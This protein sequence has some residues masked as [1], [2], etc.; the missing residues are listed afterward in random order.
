MLVAGE[1]FEAFKDSVSEYQGEIERVKEENRC[2][3]ETLAEIDTNRV[4]PRAGSQASYADGVR[5]HSSNPE[6]LDSEPSVIQ[7]KLELAT[8]K[9]E[10]EPPPSL[11]NPYTC[12][13]SPTHS[14]EP[15][16]NI[17]ET[18]DSGLNTD[19]VL[20]VKAEPDECQTFPSS[21]RR[22]SGAQDK[23]DAGDERDP[24]SCSYCDQTFDEVSHLASHLQSHMVLFN[25]EVCGKSFKKKG[26]LRTHMIVH[27][28]E[29]PFRCKL[30]GKSYSC[31]KVLNVHLISHTGERPF[32]CGYCEKRFKLKSHLKEHERIHTGEKPFSCPVCR[33]CFSRSN[34]VKIHIRSRH[35]E[36]LHLIDVSGGGAMRGLLELRR[37]EEAAAEV[38]F[39]MACS[40]KMAQL[41]TLNSFFCERLLAVAAEI[42][43]AVKDTLSEYQ[44]EVDRSK[45]EIVYLRKMLAEVSISTGADAQT[46]QADE[47]PVEQHN[48]NE[49]PLESS[50]IQ[51]KLEL[52]AMEQETESQ[53]PSCDAATCC[54]PADAVKASEPP[55]YKTSAMAEQTEDI[56]VHMD[57]HVT[58]KLEQCPDEL[59]S[60][61]I[62][63]ES[64]WNHFRNTEDEPGP[65]PSSQC[66][67]SHQ[68]FHLQSPSTENVFHYKACGKPFKGGLLKTHM[69]VHHK[70]RTYRC[71]LCGKCYSTSYALKLHLRT[72]TGER[73]YTCKFCVKTFN[74]KAHV[75]EHERIHTGEKPYSCSVCGKHFNRTYQVKVHIR[76]Y[77]PDEV[78]TIIRSRQHNCT[79]YTLG[80]ST[81]IEC[82]A[83]VSLR[84]TEE[85][86]FAMASCNNVLKFE[87]L[88]VFIHE[89]LTATAG[90]IFQAVKD[91]L[92]EFQEEIYR[93]TQ[94]NI[95]LK[96][97]LADVSSSE[98]DAQTKQDEFP[99]E[100]ENPE[101]QVKLEFSTVHQD[102]GT[103]SAC[104]FVQ[105][106]TAYG[107]PH[108]ASDKTVNC[109]DS[110][111][112]QAED[113]SPQNTNHGP[114]D[115]VVQV[116][117]ELSTVQQDAEPQ[118]PCFQGIKETLLLF[119]SHVH[120]ADEKAILG[121][122]F[123][124]FYEH[125]LKTKGNETSQAVPQELSNFNQEPLD[126][127]IQVKVELSTMHQDA[128]SQGPPNNPSSSS[129]P[130]TAAAYQ[131]PSYH[132]SEKTANEEKVE[133]GIHNSGVT[134]KLEPWDSQVIYSDDGPSEMQNEIIAKSH[135]EGMRDDQGT[136]S[137][138]QIPLNNMA[139]SETLLQG[140]TV[141]RVVYCEYCGKPFGNREQLKQHLVVHQKE[142]PRPY[143]CDLCEKSY[144]YAQVLEI[145][146][147]THTGE[148]PYHSQD[149]QHT[150]ADGA[151]LEQGSTQRPLNSDPS[152]LQLKLELAAIKQEA[153]PQV[154]LND[155][156]ASTS[157]CAKSAPVY[158]GHVPEC[159]LPSPVAVSQQRESKRWADIQPCHADA[160]Q[161]QTNQGPPDSEPDSMIQVKLELCTVQ[162]ELEPQQPLT[163][164]PC[165][166]T[167]MDTAVDQ[168]PL[169]GLPVKS[170]DTEEKGCNDMKVDPLP[171][172]AEICDSQA[173]CTENSDL[174]ATQGEQ[175]SVDY[176]E[177]DEDDSSSRSHY[178]V[179]NASPDRLS[180]TQNDLADNLFYCK[181]CNKP[182]KTYLWLEKHMASHNNEERHV[183]GVCGKRFKLAQTLESHIN[184]HTRERPHSCRFCGKGFSQKSHVRDH[185]RI[186][187]GEKPFVCPI[188][189]K[190]FVQRSQLMTHIHTH[191]YLMKDL[192]EGPRVWRKRGEAQNARCLRSKVN[193]AI[194]QEVLEHFMLPAADQLYGDADFIFQQVLAPAHSAKATS[195]WFKDHAIPVPNWPAN[196]PD[197]NPIKNLWGIVKRKMRY[198]R[199]NNA[200]E[201]KATI[202]AT[203][204]LITPE[205]CHKLI[206]SCHAA[207]LQ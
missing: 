67:F 13:S 56:G 70:A 36:Q 178:R 21:N 157:P 177:V 37:E 181:V 22:L 88:N 8:L 186:H 89:R 193:A 74:Q 94:E 17:S 146:R 103:S 27:Q 204:A 140:E 174:S 161:D 131:E 158:H 110:Q 196:S 123:G 144:S 170:M 151:P 184:N 53:Q 109:E 100:E 115:S 160:N 126:S 121:I 61:A 73:P 59:N 90:D 20:M 127:I 145:H 72:H 66:D 35:R 87:S 138:C 142:K 108:S 124:V 95:Y 114:L 60:C 69:V 112:S 199:P 28:K 111:L 141:E 200:E 128:E 82:G 173:S 183:C 150:H 97:R 18:D 149:V 4:E 75:K 49:E 175:E 91:V 48:S 40:V 147:R 98:S 113:V 81:H 206:H 9:Q 152:V 135:F 10:C 143:R 63:T 38:Q 182:F 155:P 57:S 26:T 119:A 68:S 47:G 167:H 169:P 32:G 84:P 52:S 12:T 16:W 122:P 41:E 2:L 207:F 165:S 93:S 77:H 137:Q 136:S 168:E 83:A 3:R 64:L 171:V 153:E 92:A 194:Y 191:S 39:A 104:N 25:C 44:D 14:P 71:D 190:G 51:V 19:S 162:Q 187:T 85:E 117:L 180:Q 76:N 11:N 7:V 107:P 80:G 195:T 79:K 31:A 164:V 106:A 29:R 50:V 105:E 205:Q 86:C 166:T 192:S 148:R 154:T 1:I 120:V 134:I 129:S 33:K 132:Y 172:K 197:L 125:E 54:V 43:Q 130:S 176:F 118:Q 133:D 102:P 78:A 96:R 45:R 65:H 46:S 42:Y 23:A 185:E 163:V 139:H 201:L 189:Q 202:R 5:K 116:K 99:L 30:C 198:A 156:S 24:L 15:A 179:F 101:I 188:C 62:Q 203:W 55:S 159:L 34:A 58:V 6:P